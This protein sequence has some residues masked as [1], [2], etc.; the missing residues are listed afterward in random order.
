MA[1]VKWLLRDILKNL[2]KEDMKAFQ[3]H[4]EISKVPKC[5]MEDADVIDTVDNMVQFYG[6][7]RAVK[8]TV[9]ILGKINQNELAGQLKNNHKQAQTKAIPADPVLTGATS[10]PK[11]DRAWKMDMLGK[12]LWP[13]SRLLP[14]SPT[15]GLIERHMEF[16]KA[17][18]LMRNQDRA[19]KMDMLGKDLWPES[20]LLPSSPTGGLIERH[21][22]FRKAGE[23]M[24]NQDRAWKMDMLGKDLWPESRLLPSSP[25]GGLIERHMEFRKAGELMRNQGDNIAHRAR[26]D[27]QKYAHKQV[28]EMK[29]EYKCIGL[30]EEKMVIHAYKK[31]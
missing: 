4:L 27:I 9:V 24:R 20:R 6:E 3:R 13:E 25:A 26:I 17:G 19:W 5:K 10:K 11:E 14:S 7:E 1:S 31:H 2:R 29:A 23:L 12:D 21:M 16:R 28:L 30:S 8:V 15:G 22:E 18:E